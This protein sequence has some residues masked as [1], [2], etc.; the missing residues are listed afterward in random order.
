MIKQQS[1]LNGGA[2]YFGPNMSERPLSPKTAMVSKGET[3]ITTML[4]PFASSFIED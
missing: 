1:E 2:S 3:P 4:K